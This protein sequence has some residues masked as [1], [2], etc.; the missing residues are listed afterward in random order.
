MER[1]GATHSEGRE[2]IAKARDPRPIELSLAYPLAEML[3]GSKNL[4]KLI[5]QERK[6]LE[7][8]YRLFLEA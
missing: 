1:G 7:K 4:E 3:G 6:N 8:A 5:V 2:L